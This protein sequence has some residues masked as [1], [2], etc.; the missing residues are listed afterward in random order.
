MPSLQIPALLTALDIDIV[1]QVVE[2]Y[3]DAQVWA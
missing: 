3:H 1:A 2:I